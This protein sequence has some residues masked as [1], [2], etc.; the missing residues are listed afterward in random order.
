MVQPVANEFTTGEVTDDG[1]GL[2][3]SRWLADNLTGAVAADRTVVVE[4]GTPA[5]FALS[6][7]DV[8]H[9]SR[10][11]G[12]GFADLADRGSTAL[13]WWFLRTPG[14]VNLGWRVGTNGILTGLNARTPSNPQGGVRPALII[15]Q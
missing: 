2:D 7:A 11:A 13:G 8:D 10:I 12:I 14:P 5:A 6:L 9:L 1:A 4:D 3:G 15:H